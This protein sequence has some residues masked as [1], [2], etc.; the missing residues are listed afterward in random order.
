[1]DAAFALQQIEGY[2]RARQ[3]LPTLAAVPDWHWPRRL[4]LEQCS[5]ELTAQYKAALIRKAFTNL[6]IYKSAN[7][8]L[9]GADLTGGF[10]IDTYF[11]SQHFGEWHYVEM[12][13]ELCRIAEHNFAQAERQ[14]I[15]IHCTSAEQFLEEQTARYQ[16]IYLDPAR[17]DDHGGKVFRLQD[18]TPD[19]TT[20][21]PTLRERCQFLLIKLSPMLDLHDALR[22]LPDASEVHIIAVDNE[23]KELLVL[24][25]MGADNEGKEIGITCVN[26]RKDK[27]DER[28]CFTPAEEAATSSLTNL[29][30][31]SFANSYLYEPNAAIMKSGAFQL[32][33]ERFGLQ[34]LAPSTHL[35][36]S[37][38]RVDD[39]PG[40]I[41][42]IESQLQKS[43]TKALAG[44][45]FNIICRNYPLRPEELRKKFRTRDGGEQYIIGT[46]T[47]Q[48][49]LLLAS[50]LK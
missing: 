9:A 23:V 15:R 27:E 41:F 3:K 50:R 35:Y 29:H 39:F 14:N 16:L 20:L 45:P 7:C 4:S 25:Q 36:V 47:S 6:Q 43:D 11:L 32:V 1:V 5:S 22:H 2:Q 48:P 31:S 34:K 30:I 21:Y 17:R 42:R 46:R 18:C 19:L 12:Q 44:Q 49:I 28:F 33:G 10:G 40:R 13:E 24:C 26:L 37:D 8:P 38:Q